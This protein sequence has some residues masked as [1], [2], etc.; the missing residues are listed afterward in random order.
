MSHE[1]RTPMNGVIGMIELLLE[2]KQDEVQRDYAETAGRSAGALLMIINDILDFSKVEA[3][4]LE[5]ECI[6][7]NL[8]DTVQDVAR[9]LAIQAHAKKLELTVAIDPQVPESVRG[10]P[11]RLRQ[12]L[13]NLGGNAIKFTKQGEVN[14]ELK[15]LSRTEDATI[16][17]FEIR[18]T[19]IGIPAHRLGALFQPFS[20]VDSSNTREFGGTGLGL[21]IVR[22]LVEL[23]GGDSGVESTVGVGSRFWFTA[24]F[25]S[26]STMARPPRMAPVNVKNLRILV[27]DDNATNRKVL[28]AHL[29]HIGCDATC[30]A[31]ADEA[32]D[33][34][35]A[36]VLTSRPFDVALVDHHMPHRDGADLGRQIAAN[37]SLR[38]TRLILL[39]SSG[40]DGDGCHLAEGVFAG[41]LL[42]PVAQRDLLACL[43]APTTRA[44]AASG[45]RHT[46]PIASYS[47]SPQL[48]AFQP[49]NVLVAED[50]PVNQKI[51]RKVLE[52]MGLRVTIVDDGRAAVEA[53]KS[54]RFDLILMDCQMPELDGYQ[55]T[56]EIRRSEIGTNHI[57]I[58]ALTAHAMKGTDEE[59]RAAGMDD[60]VTKPIDRQRLRAALDR[61]LPA[62][63]AL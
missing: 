25:A 18:D 21:S 59:C 28:A 50:N 45:P 31:S 62:D 42:K 16:V 40:R 5:L 60:H 17:Q 57:P 34:M 32:I 7:M 55:A 30:A 41:S 47:D 51:V 35:R 29:G 52:T 9:L 33:M 37:K 22:R 26:A 13:L 56:A 49:H 58:I 54:Q 39:T 61:F 11:G 44:N 63:G 19:G 48:R 14:I 23:M 27:V 36:E 43:L 2:T 15:T 4:K 12:V 46:Q 6:D 20:Q 1:I 8:P 53:W 3:G 10:D 24:K 38:H